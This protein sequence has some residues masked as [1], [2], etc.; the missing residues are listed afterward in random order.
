MCGRVCEFICHLCVC[1]V[2]NETRKREKISTSN[3]TIL[4]VELVVP[5][6]MGAW[7]AE[8]ACSGTLRDQLKQGLVV[9]VGADVSF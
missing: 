3:G 9:T 5:S 7:L 8:F 1:N 4:M 6:H 2:G